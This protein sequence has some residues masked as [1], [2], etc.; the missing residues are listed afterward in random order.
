MDKMPMLD[1]DGAWDSGLG[2]STESRGSHRKP[3]DFL[4]GLLRVSWSYAEKPLMLFQ[5]IVEELERVE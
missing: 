5:T 1:L 3:V 2:S 4:F